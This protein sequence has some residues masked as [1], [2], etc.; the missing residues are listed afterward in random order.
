MFFLECGVTEVLKQCSVGTS[1]KA[2]RGRPRRS[3]GDNVWE[4]MEER[5]LNG[6]DAQERDRCSLGVDEVGLPAM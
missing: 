4:V 1:E 6:D 3:C 5:E 2:T